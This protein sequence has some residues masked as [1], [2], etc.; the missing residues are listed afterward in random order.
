MANTINNLEE[1]PGV[2]AKM[3]AQMFDDKVHFLKTIDRENSSVYNGMNGF[4]AGDTVQISKFARFIPGSTA[5]VTS[6]LQDI[7]EEK[8]SLSL[9]VRRNI[10]VSMTSAEI[11]TDL[12]L[13]KWTKRVLEPA[14][15]SIANYVESA[16]LTKA[17]DSTFNI[18]GTPGSTVFDTDTAL[19]AGQRIDENNCDDA[20]NRFMLLTPAARRSAVNA[21]KGLFQSSDEIAKQYK[22]GAMGIADGFTFL[23]NNRLPIHTNGN[24]VAFE[25]STTVSTEGQSTLVV[26]GLSTSPDGTVTKGTVFTIDTVNAVDPITKEDLGYLQEFV[27]TADAT[28][29]SGSATLNISPP[30]YTS[31]SNGLQNVTAFPTDGD[32]CNVKTGSASTGYRQN[33]AYHKNAFRMVSVPLPNY[34]G[35]HL[36]ATETINDISIRVWMDADI[37]TD[38]MIC[39]LDFLGGL[40][41]VQEGWA[42]RITE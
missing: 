22:S 1:A 29:S 38:K 42:V 21:R 27:V 3:A 6:S 8:T 23:S 4:Q 10:P 33:L 26:E 12:G 7:V 25:V 18:V 41:A 31:A 24:D 2:I 16:F 20:D 40:A 5:D 19:A 17:V 9:D 30:I 35:A 32:T 36:C 15:S 37:L 28:G 13:S 39:R 14:M 34:D 11:F